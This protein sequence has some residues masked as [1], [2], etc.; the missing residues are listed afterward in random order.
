M[1]GFGPKMNHDVRFAF[2]SP[3]TARII[4]ELMLQNQKRRLHSQIAAW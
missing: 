1:T 3:D 4:Y 2:R